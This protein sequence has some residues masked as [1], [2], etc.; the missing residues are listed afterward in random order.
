[1][2]PVDRLSEELEWNAR[3]CRQNVSSRKGWL[4]GVPLHGHTRCDSNHKIFP[5]PEMKGGPHLPIRAVRSCGVE[6]GSSIRASTSWLYYPCRW[7]SRV[8]RMFAS[9]PSAVGCLLLL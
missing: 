5:A 4:Q 8:K 1:M 9:L 2:S 3:S 6:P 7:S